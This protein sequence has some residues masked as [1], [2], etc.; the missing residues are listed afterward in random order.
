MA[1]RFVRT[2][3]AYLGMVGDESAE[4]RQVG[5]VAAP[6]RQDRSRSGLLVVVVA[7]V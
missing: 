1:S 5:T 7:A 6:A 3:L 2:A 4:S